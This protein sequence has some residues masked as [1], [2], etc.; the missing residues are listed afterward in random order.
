MLPLQDHFP[1][2][3]NSTETNCTEKGHGQNMPRN[4]APQGVVAY[5]IKQ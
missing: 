5:R 3:K 1:N 2:F 4:L